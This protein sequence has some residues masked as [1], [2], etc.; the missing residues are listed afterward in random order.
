MSPGLACTG[1]NSRI[2][3]DYAMILM[4][5]WLT[6][7]ISYCWKSTRCPIG[8]NWSSWISVYTK[9]LQMVNHATYVE[10][11]GH[12]VDILII[13]EYVIWCTTQP[14]DLWYQ[15]IHFY[16][17][18]HSRHA[19]AATRMTSHFSYMSS[20]LLACAGG[21]LPSLLL[22]FSV[23]INRVEYTLTQTVD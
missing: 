17:S 5:L 2:D 22:N 3:D 12:L 1:C 11:I 13:W 6:Y 15:Y 4:W 19:I 7:S 18:R 10:T 20:V 8:E 21:I 14:V 9:I 16:N 23:Y